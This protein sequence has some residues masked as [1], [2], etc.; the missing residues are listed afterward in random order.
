[1]KYLLLLL[2]LFLTGCAEPY[3]HLYNI[4]S[5]DVSKQNEFFVFENDTVQITY[6]FWSKDGG[7]LS[8]SIYNNTNKPIYID[9]KKSSF[10]SNNERF[11]Y[12]E[13]GEISIT[14][15]IAYTYGRYGY[16]GS[17]LAP[18]PSRL[19]AITVSASSTTTVKPERVTFIPPESYVSKNTFILLP[20][21]INN[22]KSARKTK[23]ES[24]NRKDSLTVYV[25]RY[26]KDNTPLLF[27]NYITLSFSED[28]SDEFTLS[29]QFY[30]N[31]IIELPQ[32]EY[33]TT[34]V[35]SKGMQSSEM[36]K[37]SSKFYFEVPDEQSLGNI[38]R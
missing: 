10:I 22:Y 35:D 20:I 8:F 5:T 4:E 14:K 11:K 31:E 26:G 17:T 24:Q 2:I 18:R 19:S 3:Y 30:V 33:L 21:R 15:G 1:M 34:F 27:Q 23:I 25:S 6:S 32:S 28:F 38:I 7:V 36:Y 9:W 13:D 12:W 29:H 37:S 16:S